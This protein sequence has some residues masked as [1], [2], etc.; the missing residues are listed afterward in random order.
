MAVVP[1]RWW[2]L[3][4][5]APG[6]YHRVTLFALLAL[7]FIVV[8]GAAVR[9]TGSGLGCP[10]WPQCQDGSLAPFQPATGHHAWIEFVNRVI[11]GL[12]S[13]AV[14]A[15]VLGSLLRQPRRRDL[16]RLSWGLVI[17]VAAQIVLGGLTVLFHLAPLFVMGH[18]LLSMVLVANAVVLHHRAGQ[19]GGAQRPIVAPEVRFMGRALVAA[20]G[21]TLVTGT[22]VT[23][24]GPHGGDERARRLDLFV[25]DIARLH[26]VSEN[27][28]LLSTLAT[29]WLLH[30]T[31]A[32]GVVRRRAQ[33]LLAV[34]VAQAAVG[35]TQYATGV[36]VLL[37]GVH[38][39]GAV[40]VWVAVLRFQLGLRQADEEPRPA[41]VPLV[42]PAVAMGVGTSP[43]A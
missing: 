39:F 12:V 41:P 27:L 26:G 5:L 25:P 35:Y 13:V 40:C 32:P 15:A 36:P 31:G 43:I 20:A 33:V 28:F 37:V 9:L 16:V 19:A 42:E 34:M 18:F 22:L 1:A 11:T 38:V 14:G 2:P 17:G 29:L 21:L 4:R 23:A 8:T 6:T 30:R 7:G 10:T 3:P 24:A